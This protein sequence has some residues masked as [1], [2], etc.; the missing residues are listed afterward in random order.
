MRTVRS[1]LIAAS[2]LAST[3]CNT[4][5][6]T[7]DASPGTNDEGGSDGVRAVLSWRMR[8]DSEHCPLEEAPPRAIDAANGEEGHE[9]FCDLTMEGDERRL[10]F[11]ARDANGNGIDVRGAR[12][13]L[14][15]GRLLG[16][17]CQMRIYETADVDLFAPC[18]SNPSSPTQPCQI[19]RVNL[20]NVGGVAT[21][22]GEFRC[23]DIALAGHNNLRDVT[24]P[25]SSTGFA[26]FAFTGCDG[27]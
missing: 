24:S 1:S 5:R 26:E 10:R 12:I 17:L 27:L 7:G 19:Q 16:S 8:C 2:L 4:V 20:Q 21:M 22:T 25:T 15:G 14:D 9:V 23:Q 18:G 3:A 6:A 13:G 11:T